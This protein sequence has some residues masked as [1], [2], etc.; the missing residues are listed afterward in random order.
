MP[1]KQHHIHCSALNAPKLPPKVR[2]ASQSSRRNVEGARVVPRGAWK[3]LS[4]GADTSLWCLL[5][6]L[7]SAA[8]TKCTGASLWLQV[9]GVQSEDPHAVAAVTTSSPTKADPTKEPF[10]SIAAA[11]NNQ[12]RHHSTAAAA[13]AATCGKSGCAT[14]SCDCVASIPPDLCLASYGSPTWQPPF[15]IPPVM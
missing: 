5:T 9:S 1:Y 12:L 11:D 3:H 8:A 2:H 6:L 15:C 13:A 10:E 14:W 4:K 7:G